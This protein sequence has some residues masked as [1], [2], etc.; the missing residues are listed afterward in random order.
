MA[1]KY[2]IFTRSF[3]G[4]ILKK[5]DIHTIEDD[6]SGPTTPLSLGQIIWMVI[7]VGAIFGSIMIADIFGLW[8]GI[9]L[10]VTYFVLMVWLTNRGSKQRCTAYNAAELQRRTALWEEYGCLGPRPTH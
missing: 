9:A 3:I 6:S 2:T 8:F 4:N 10:F 1:K 7:F 5:T